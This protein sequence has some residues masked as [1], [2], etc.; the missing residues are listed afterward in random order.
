MRRTLTITDTERDSI[1][2]A[3]VEGVGA[4]WRD[5]M[6]ASAKATDIPNTW[7]AW[8]Q[9]MVDDRS[10]IWVGRPGKQG[11]VS[12]ID[13]FSADGVL[14]GSA[15]PPPGFKMHGTWQGGRLYQTSETD[16]GLPQVRV[17]RVDTKVR[18][19]AEGDGTAISSTN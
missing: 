3:T 2:D 17:W 10:R 11:A 19:T 12:T 15:T 16:D 8:S 9:V 1:Y 7:P 14:L 5:A 13:I 4:Q 18:G 6:R